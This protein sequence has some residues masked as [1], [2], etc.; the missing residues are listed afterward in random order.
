MEKWANNQAEQQKNAGSGNI[1][2]RNILYVCICV[3]P[4]EEGGL[5][6]AQAMIRE[7]NV[8]RKGNAVVGYIGGKRDAPR[9]GQLGC[10]GFIVVKEKIDEEDNLKIGLEF[11]T[12]KT[13]AFLD[14]RE[15][16]FRDLEKVVAGV[17]GLS[18]GGNS[19]GNV[20]KSQNIVPGGG[21]AVDAALKKLEEQGGC[22][23]C[24]SCDK[25]DEEDNAKEEL[26]KM[27]TKLKNNLPSVNNK[28]MDEE[29][30]DTV[31]LLL[32]LL[33]KAEAKK[34]EAVEDLLTALVDDL[35][36]HFAHEE[37]LLTELYGSNCSTFS[38]KT[39]HIEDHSRVLRIVRAAKS[40][41]VMDVVKVCG[42]WCD[43]VGMFDSKYAADLLRRR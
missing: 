26:Q 6:L 8:G 30:Q 23:E 14:Y 12:R 5:Q 33:E 32:K 22:V 2:K 39:G 43:H 11:I 1:I 40:V 31:K 36:Q 25:A 42:A 28:N 29:H 16:A 13:I 20:P 4:P 3:V 24:E 15:R 10:S 21:P 38:Q 18:S 35:E 19:G 41:S 17:G 9:F 7:T 34:T 37:D 27:K